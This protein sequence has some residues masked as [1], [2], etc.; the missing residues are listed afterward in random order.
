MEPLHFDSGGFR[1]LVRKEPSQRPLFGER[2]LRPKQEMVS[3]GS[4]EFTIDGNETRRRVG[5]MEGEIPKPD[6]EGPRR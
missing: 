5:K 4:R 6:Y 3:Q 2:T 1:Y